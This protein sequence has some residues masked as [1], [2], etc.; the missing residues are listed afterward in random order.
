V[1]FPASLFDL[2]E[3]SLPLPRAATIADCS[4]WQAAVERLHEGAGT[5]HP[6]K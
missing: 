1:I 6:Y 3:I 5:A 4:E 2:S